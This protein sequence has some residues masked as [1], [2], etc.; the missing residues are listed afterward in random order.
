MTDMKDENS[1]RMTGT[2][3]NEEL[4][5]AQETLL[6]GSETEESESGGRARTPR[7]YSLY[8]KFADHVSL[9]T[10]DAVILISAALIIVLLI[11]GIATGTH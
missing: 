3:T 2:E 7:R 9:R 8:D 1:G 6:E 11:Y 4:V 5:E 10:I